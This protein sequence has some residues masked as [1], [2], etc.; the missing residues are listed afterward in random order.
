VTTGIA[1]APRIGRSDRAVTEPWGERDDRLAAAVRAGDERAFESLFARYRAPIRAY[2]ASLVRDPGY[3]E[4]VTQDV[5]IS[6][7]RSLRAGDPPTM[8][9]P[10][11]Y[12][13]A[14]NACI[15]RHRRTLRGEELAGGVGHQLALDGAQPVSPRAEEEGMIEARARFAELC[16]T[17]LNMPAVDRRMLVMREFEG[18]TY[19]EIVYRSGMSGAAVES[20]LFRARRR[21]FERAAEVSDHDGPASKN[22]SGGAVGGTLAPLRRATRAAV[23]SVSSSR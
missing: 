6:V 9:R 5:F 18:R 12:E 13:I 16:D 21:L 23:A 14:R 4:D 8:F 3:A 22:A 20:A 19:R 11:L 15:D 17:L 1:S 2:V 7:L 10:W